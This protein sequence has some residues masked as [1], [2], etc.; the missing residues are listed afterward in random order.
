LAGTA[1]NLF[2]TTVEE[3]PA[4]G[5]EILAGL[6]A[7][8]GDR[9]ELDRADRRLVER[10]P[11]TATGE[12]DDEDEEAKT[13]FEPFL[14]P[15]LEALAAIEVLMGRVAHRLAADNRACGGRR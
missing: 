15:Q 9:L 7:D 4:V 8:G 5:R 12:D 2:A 1:E 6:V 13:H 3:M 14:Y 10:G 11:R